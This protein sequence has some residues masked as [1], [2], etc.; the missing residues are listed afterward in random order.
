MK[1]EYQRLYQVADHIELLA[2]YLYKN[3]SLTI[4][5]MKSYLKTYKEYSQ[6]HKEFDI[7]KLKSIYI[8][9]NLKETE[10]KDTL[11]KK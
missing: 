3:P 5:T 11:I 8:E 6:V 10:N 1:K 2:Y 7:K 9:K 4:Q